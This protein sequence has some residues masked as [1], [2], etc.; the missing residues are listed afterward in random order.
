MRRE[1]D[2]MNKR[3]E[4]ERE[5]QRHKAVSLAGIVWRKGIFIINLLQEQE[6]V[7]QAMLQAQIEEAEE[8]AQREKLA[9][10]EQDRAKRE[11]PSRSAHHISQSIYDI[12]IIMYS[13]SP[14]PSKLPTDR[15]TLHMCPELMTIEQLHCTNHC[16]SNRL[17]SP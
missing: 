13:G 17:I 2:E 11:L 8:A 9:Q 15:L 4:R 1:I 16:H 12:T 10:R 5:R 14:C 6:R 7:W 3:N